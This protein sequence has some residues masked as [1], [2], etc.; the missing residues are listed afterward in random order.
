TGTVLTVTY[1]ALPDDNYALTLVSGGANFTDLAG[2]ALDGEF[3]GSYPSGNGTAGG[4]FVIGLSLDP[5]TQAYPTPLSAQA[6]LGSLIYDPSLTGT[7]AFVG[8]T[9]GFTL[10]VDP[11]QT[12]SVL[13]SSSATGFQ[14]TVQLLN[15]SNVVIGSASAAVPG[16]NALLQTIPA[17]AGGA[18][19]VVVGSIAGSVGLYTV[20][21]TLN[22]AQENEGN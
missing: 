13:V 19:T 10:A 14:P 4:N 21:V 9:D 6:P 8:D 20:Q 18:Y 2:N 17:S 11:G 15:P 22:A 16:Q 3:I 7:I 12:I 1:S 5:G